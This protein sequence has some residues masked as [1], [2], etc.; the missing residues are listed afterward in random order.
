MSHGCD[1]VRAAILSTGKEPEIAVSQA[2]GTICVGVRSQSSSGTGNHDVQSRD[3]VSGAGRER[4]RGVRY[5]IMMCVKLV[6]S[7]VCF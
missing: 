7:D 3:Y 1:T 4:V 2:T 6:L 5:L